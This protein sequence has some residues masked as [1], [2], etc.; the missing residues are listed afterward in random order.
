MAYN[1]AMK[2]ANIA[3][4]KNHLGMYIQAVQEGEEIE[5]RRRNVPVARVVP[6]PRVRPN[7]TVLGCGRDSAVVMGD[8]TEPLIPESDWHMLAESTGEGRP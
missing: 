6:V 5:V 3:E 8:L 1:M 2:V 4:F 7:R